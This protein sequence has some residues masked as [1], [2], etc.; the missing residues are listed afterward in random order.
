[1]TFF[2]LSFAYLRDRGLNTVLN[3]ALLALAV[4]TLVILLLF[5]RQLE[6]RFDR[7]AQGIDLVVGAKGSPL[8]LILSSIYQADVPTGNIPLSSVEV[9]RENP[10]VS[11]VIPLAQGDNFRGY[12]IVGTEPAYPEHY[13]ATLA[14]GR[15]WAKTAEVVIGADV[16]NAL[17]MALGQRFVGSHGMSDDAAAQGHDHAPFIVT[18]I[19][20]PSGSVVD[21]LILTSI[22]SVWDVHGI[23]HGDEDDH[24]HDG[25]GKPDHAPGEHDHGDEDHDHEDHDH[26]S[27]G[28]QDHAA[29]EHDHG[30]EDHDHEAGGQ[31][32]DPEV[33]ALLV[34]Y[35]S[36]LAAVQLPG[37]INRQT[38]LQAAVPAVEITRLLQ[39]VGLGLDAV[40]ALAVL[41]ML[42]AGLSI[43]VALYTALRQREGDMAMLR[44]IG[45]SRA[46]IFGQMI[47][48]GVALAAAG[49][50]LGVLLGHGVIALAAANF[51]QLTELGLDAA[52]FE[53]GEVWIV[54]GALAIGALAALLP[55]VR[56]F[57]ADIAD[58]LTNS[59]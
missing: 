6:T 55:A 20:K 22:E 23:A 37:F 18:G 49:A 27:D 10:S 15:L 19:L 9:L 11:K 26:D 44:V 38:N 53:V 16:A 34:S 45:A 50:I 7:D 32:L 48:E 1:M 31:K 5:A 59:R 36:P 35:G 25:D 8:Q 57:R 13:G 17:G 4:A 24:D 58:T 2:G 29:G 39:L 21:R 14:E 40:R 41:L 42:T 30:D 28:K 33:T 3:I 12:R 46:S 47:F 43:F 56:V 54:A 52:H 51:R